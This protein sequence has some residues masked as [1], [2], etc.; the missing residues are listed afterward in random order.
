MVFTTDVDIT[1]F[2]EAEGARLTVTTDDALDALMSPDLGFRGLAQD[3][4]SGTFLTSLHQHLL[5]Q[6]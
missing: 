1:S 2:A 5:D 3:L 6:D 4:E